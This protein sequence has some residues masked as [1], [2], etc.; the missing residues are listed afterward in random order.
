M[1]VSLRIIQIKI[2][3][4]ASLSRGL[5]RIVKPY[6]RE[7]NEREIR[8]SIKDSLHNSIVDKAKHWN[9]WKVPQP[10]RLLKNGNFRKENQGPYQ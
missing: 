5:V 8:K 10:F 1:I 4:D 3:V 2:T 7:K 6:K 9:F